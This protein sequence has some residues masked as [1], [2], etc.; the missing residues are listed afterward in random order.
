MPEPSRFTFDGSVDLEAYQHD[1]RAKLRQLQ[2]DL[3]ILKLFDGVPTADDWGVQ[4]D[5][6]N[7]G[8]IEGRNTASVF[9]KVHPN[10][11]FHDDA[12]VA[13]GGFENLTSAIEKDPILASLVQRMVFVDPGVNSHEQRFRQRWQTTYKESG[14]TM[15]QDKRSQLLSL[16]SDLADLRSQFARNIDDGQ[17]N[18]LVPAD[19]LAGMPED[20]MK[21]HPANEDNQIT[22]TT[23]KIDVCPVLAYCKNDEVQRRTQHEYRSRCPGNINVLQKILQGCHNKAQILGYPNYAA[24]DLEGRLALRGLSN[25]TDFIDNVVA[26]VKPQ[27]HQ[28]KQAMSQVFGT[29]DLK[30]WQADFAKEVL[31][32]KMFSGFD[33]SHIRPYL[34]VGNVLPQITLLIQELFGVQFKHQPEVKSWVDTGVSCYDV[35]DVDEGRIMGRLYTDAST[36]SFSSR[37]PSDLIWLKYVLQLHPRDNKYSH[38]CVCIM[39]KAYGKSNLPEVILL[40]NIPEGDDALMTYAE[41]STLYHE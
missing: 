16:D 12:M 9:K 19:D 6:L 22:L 5:K 13:Q 26:M 2:N 1:W 33:S 23:R 25:V 35:Y 7:M 30:V 15:S 8:A 27:A 36:I 4:F 31:L 34:R 28:E 10:R 3:E 20:F 40:A 29:K 24:L 18:W 11:A 41:V 39:K 17:T 21:S 37:S 32:Q 38:A 14:A